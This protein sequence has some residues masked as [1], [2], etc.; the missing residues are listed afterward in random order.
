MV[1]KFENTPFCRA[2]AKNETFVWPA[3]I[4]SKKCAGGG[5]RSVGF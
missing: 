2:L 1:L 4:V 3:I 5:Y